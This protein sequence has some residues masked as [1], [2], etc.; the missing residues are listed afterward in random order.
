MMEAN[1][2]EALFSGS[3][4][5]WRTKRSIDIEI[6]E[7][8]DRSLIEIVAYS[9]VVDKERR[10]Y[11][12]SSVLVE[13]SSDPTQFEEGLRVHKEL[14]LRR[15]EDFNKEKQMIKMVNKAK[16]EYIL[17]RLTVDEFSIEE[18]SFKVGFKFTG[19]D[20]ELDTGNQ[21]ML[22][23][24]CPPSVK[25]LVSPHVRN[26]I[27]GEIETCYKHIKEE[28]C[29]IL[30]LRLRAAKSEENTC[31][32]LSVFEKW[33]LPL[34]YLKLLSKKSLSGRDA[35]IWKGGNPAAISLSLLPTVTEVTGEEASPHPTTVNTVKGH[36]KS[37]E[38]ESK[39]AALSIHRKSDPSSS[40]GRMPKQSS[41]AGHH[42]VTMKVVIDSDANGS[43]ALEEKS[44]SVPEAA[45]THTPAQS[46]ISRQTSSSVSPPRARTPKSAPRERSIGSTSPRN[47][48]EKE[49]SRGDHTDEMRSFTS[50]LKITVHPRKTGAG[51][52]PLALPLA[53]P[54]ATPTVSPT[55]AGSKS[56]TLAG[57][58]KTGSPT[59]VVVKE[60]SVPAG[61]KGS[62]PK[63]KAKVQA[64]A[65][66]HT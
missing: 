30:E 48:K 39:G 46:K 66:V 4:Q 13:L 14:C 22:L 12:N 62:T 42:A 63:A 25:I 35:A 27:E 24:A 36:A 31:K 33:R 43:G 59:H 7:H 49:N 37:N 18:R 64:K 6:V 3:K 38:D 17:S 19:G 5:Y 1:R 47:K 41:A 54:L 45:S 58:K 55:H 51:A 40:V 21:A 9:P 16:V 26:L 20:L 8:K 60:A 34:I 52:S 2:L 56:P 50:N 28:Q 11:L 29:K 32:A 57:N 44:S 10:L 23:V 15:R 53:S 65:Q 61:E